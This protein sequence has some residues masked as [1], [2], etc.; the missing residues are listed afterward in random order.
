LKT[1]PR[2]QEG[3][4]EEIVAMVARTV[5]TRKA[6][7]ST[8]QLVIPR[9]TLGMTADLLRPGLPAFADWFGIT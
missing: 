5:F 1:G 7:D 2:C 6:R 9:L 3:R 8:R 4:A